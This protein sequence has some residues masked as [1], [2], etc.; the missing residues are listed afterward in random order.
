VWGKGRCVGG[1]RCARAA[2]ADCSRV[3][4]LHLLTTLSILWTLPQCALLDPTASLAHL[5]AASAHPVHSTP[6]LV[7]QL[8]AAAPLVH[9][10]TC[11]VFRSASRALMLVPASSLAP[12]SPTAIAT[13]PHSATFMAV[14]PAASSIS[15]LTVLHFAS[16]RRRALTQ[17]AAA[18][19]AALQST[20]L[21]SASQAHPHP[22]SAPKATA[23]ARHALPAVSAPLQARPIPRFVNTALTPPWS[24]QHPAPPAPRARFRQ[25]LGRLHATAALPA[26]TVLQAHRSSAAAPSTR[27]PPL[28]VAPVPARPA[29]GKLYPPGGRAS[30]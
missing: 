10:P 19:T 16:G 18:P 4:Q 3:A 1:T 26:L 22:L 9:L 15:Y 27:M 30:A 28:P 23:H 7:N 5:Y 8:A 11:P 21:T 12:S 24:V 29:L 17:L 13:A 25:L 20:L 6:S 2:A 14:L